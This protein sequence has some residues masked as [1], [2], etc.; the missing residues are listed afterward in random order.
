MDRETAII[1]SESD[2]NLINKR[3][4]GLTHCVLKLHSL[5]SML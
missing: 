2:A 3:G 1:A 5:I 4:E